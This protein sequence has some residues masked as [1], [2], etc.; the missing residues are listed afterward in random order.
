MWTS[1][2]WVGTA[3]SPG[4]SQGLSLISCRTQGSVFRTGLNHGLS[5]PLFL[6]HRQGHRHP[7]PGLTL[8]SLAL[9]SAKG[10]FYTALWAAICLS[11]G[12]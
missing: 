11:G 4:V 9:P 5:Q 2:G 6:S 12:S 3:V 7:L 1:S 8:S 10:A